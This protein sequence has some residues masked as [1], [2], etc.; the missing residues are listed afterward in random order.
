MGGVGRG[1]R[2]AVASSLDSPTKLDRAKVPAREA[3]W[4]LNLYPDAAEAGGCF[5][6]NGDRRPGASWEIDPERSANEAARRARGKVHRYCAAN[7]LNR[8]AT[9]TYAPPF[10]RD[11]G[12][13]RADV[14][15]FFRKLRRRVDRP[16]PYLWVP[17][18]HADGE[19]Y[20]VHFAVGRYVPRGWI[21]E[22]WGHGWVFIKLHGDLPTG[23]GSLGEARHSARYLAKYIGKALDG[24]LAG[25]H[26]Y[27]VAQGFGPAVVRL[28][29]ETVQ[30]V[31]GQASA[32]MGSEPE[33]VWE[34]SEKETWAGPPAVWA[35]WAR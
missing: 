29:G 19:R 6:G 18:F 24:G 28:T 21:V 2:E 20:H 27:E 23:S 10:C 5:Q 7:R 3:R 4:L 16:L 9:L 34:S 11:A 22:A 1:G 14:G 12:E 15:T 30:D 33:L 32:L 8:L 25:L 31:V 35:R 13:V 26:R 17:E